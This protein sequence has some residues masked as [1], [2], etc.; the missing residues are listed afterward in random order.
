M[1]RSIT[2]VAL[3]AAMVVGA[4]GDTAT[5]TTSPV[6]ETSV[7]SAATTTAVVP[8]TQ[9]ATT[10]T[11]PAT[12]AVTTTTL[13]PTTTTA[14]PSAAD[15]LAPFF[16]AAEVLDLDIAAVAAAFNASFDDAAATV[17]PQ[18]AA[19]ISA[20]GTN[21]LTGLIP[22]GLDIDLET[23]V[24]AVY[25][26]L[27]SRIAALDGG[28]RY[29]NQGEFS[30]VEFT[31]L[32]LGLGSDSNARFDDDLAAA[33]ALA[34]TSPRPTAAA[35]SEEAGVLAVRIET[36]RL[37]NWGCDSCGGVAIDDPIA[38]DWAGRT[39]TD[40]VEFDASFIGGAWDIMIHAC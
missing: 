2:S 11:A 6:P 19:D 4:C 18:V 32:C 38:V 1:T 24:L 25:A 40:G 21:L 16:A 22:P 5:T 14:G 23:A 29:L 28:V 15:D 34:A 36:I 37:M 10:T 20:L 31:M 33:R 27:E 35:D 12:T 9:A 39:V 13:P 17:D 26:D 8:T 7:P 30:D 3:L